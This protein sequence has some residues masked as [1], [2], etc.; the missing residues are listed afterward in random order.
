MN[1]ENFH[2]FRIMARLTVNPFATIL[3]LGKGKRMDVQIES[4]IDGLTDL[5]QVIGKDGK[6]RRWFNSLAEKPVEERRNIIY[7][8]SSRL[9]SLQEDAQLVRTL[10]LLAVPA[11]FEAACIALQNIY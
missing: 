3:W 1:G 6:L 10:K 5:V 7:V 9:A 4:M 11:V 8:M 2:F